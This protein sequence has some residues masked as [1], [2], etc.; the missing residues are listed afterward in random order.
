MTAAKRR[1][2][3]RLAERDE[4]NPPEAPE[5]T[6]NVRTLHGF[7]YFRDG[8]GWRLMELRIPHDVADDYAVKSWEPDTLGVTTA[9][10][11]NAMALT[12]IGRHRER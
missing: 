1:R 10:V 6:P 3:Q 8:A 4:H 2:R 12:A 11:E 5:E 7:A 9:R